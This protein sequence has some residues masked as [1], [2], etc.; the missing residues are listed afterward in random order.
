MERHQPTGAECQCPPGCRPAPRQSKRGGGTVGS[1]PGI[2]LAVLL[3]RLCSRRGARACRRFSLLTRVRVARHFGR[4]EGRRQLARVRLLAF[5]VLFQSSPGH[6]DMM[7]F[8]VAE[9]E[10][11]SE[12]V[13]LLQARA[14]PGRPRPPASAPSPSPFLSSSPS[15]LRPT[16]EVRRQLKRRRRPARRHTSAGT[17]QQVA[18]LPR[19]VREE[20]HQQRSACGRAPVPCC[21][22]TSLTC[23]AARARRP[24]RR[25]RS[26]CA[27]WRCAR[28]RC[29]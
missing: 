4:L 7:A 22:R 10:F 9:A 12:L 5:Y 17:S 18:G 13:G 14:W 11:V 20:R 8:F 29:S 23:A 21:A 2:S 27:R 26:S 19:A 24:T 15:L 28:W 6:D 16:Q 25:C 1:A 3:A